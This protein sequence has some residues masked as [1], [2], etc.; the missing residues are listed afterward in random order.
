MT[1]KTLRSATVSWLMCS[2]TLGA[3]AVVASPMLIGLQ[4]NLTPQWRTI[5]GGV[6]K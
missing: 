2:F 5:S 3:G 4:P 6:L 1:R